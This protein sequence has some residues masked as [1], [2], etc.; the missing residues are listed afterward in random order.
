MLTMVCSGGGCRWEGG[1]AG[2]SVALLV[3]NLGSTPVMEQY[4]VARRAIEQLEA[5]GATVARVFVGPFMTS[6][7]MSGVS[8]TVFKLAQFED[9]AKEA[10]KARPSM[11]LSPGW[12]KLGTEPLALLDA[13]AKIRADEL[14]VEVGAWRGF[15]LTTGLLDLTSDADF[16]PA[17][18]VVAADLLYLR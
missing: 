1:L 7:D 12:I 9:L 2:Q 8:L 4:V 13:A 18:I 14:G 6:L 17:D 10:V 11:S 16:P 5:S 3:N 15:D